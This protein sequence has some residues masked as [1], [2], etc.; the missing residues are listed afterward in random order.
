MFHE[1][2]S[3]RK[4]NDKYY[5]VYCSTRTGN[6]TTL[7]YAIADKPLGPYTYG[8]VLVDVTDLDPKSWNIH[9]G[10]QELNGEWYI[11]YHSSSNNSNGSRRTRTEK[12]TFNTDGT[13]NKSETTSS[14]FSDYLDPSRKIEA[15][16]TAHLSGGLYLTQ[17]DGGLWPLI[18]ITNGSQSV[19]RYFEFESDKRYNEFEAYVRPR[20]GG[21]I[22][23]RLDSADGVLVGALNSPSGNGS[24]W[25]SLKTFVYDITGRHAIY[26]VFRGNTGQ[27]TGDLAYFSFGVSDLSMDGRLSIFMESLPGRDDTYNPK[28]KL[29]AKEAIDAALY[30]AA[31]DAR[32]KMISFN[33]SGLVSLEAGDIEIVEASVP[34]TPGATYK[35]FIWDSL[36]MPLTRITEAG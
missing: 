34:K 31:Y 23:I 22:E 3:I 1:G 15:A 27:Q 10:M 32:G 7:E 36:F 9:G 8:G 16:Y 25:I 6:A 13:I 29:V 33:T 17:L 30:V 11:F 18:N 21:V 19:Y 28:F 35:F 4:V 20:S 5:M 26:L 14:G 2:S 24:D 12:L